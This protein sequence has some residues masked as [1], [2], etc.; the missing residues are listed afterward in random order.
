ML[1]L[2]L[3]APTPRPPQRASPAP[4]RPAVIGRTVYGHSVQGRPL[5]A[6]H[7]GEPG[8]PGARTVVV[9]AAMHGNEAA[10]VQIMRALVS[11]P[12]LIGIDLWVIPTYN[13]DGIAAG[14]RKNAHGVDLNRNFPYGWADLDGSYESG[15]EPA[16]EPETRATMASSARST[17]PGS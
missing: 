9:M 11:G 3:L 1:L 16:S 5:V 4:R 10:P 14:T 15:P 13:P 2:G 6:Y 12:E 8:R 7:L 17:R